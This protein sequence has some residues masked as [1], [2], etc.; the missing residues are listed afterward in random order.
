MEAARPSILVFAPANR[1]GDTT[2]RDL[3]VRAGAIMFAVLLGAV[4]FYSIPGVIGG[5]AEEG[6]GWFI[7]IG[8]LTAYYLGYK[9][10]ESTSNL[11][12]L[13]RPIVGFGLVFCLAAVLIPPFF[14]TDVYCYG[15]IGWQQA[16]YGLNPYVSPLSAT[17]NWRAD[18]LFFATC[19]EDT[20]SAY[21]FLFSELA[22]AV[23]WVANGDRMLATWIFKLLNVAVFMATGW[24]IWRG[25]K[26]LG[27]SDSERTLYLFLWNPLLLLHTV[28]DG[29]NDLLMGL[30]TAAG[31]LCAVAGGCIAA[32]PWLLGG[33]LVK[34]GSV[35]LMPF[36]L[37]YLVKR[38]G[39]ARTAIGLGLGTVLC[40]SVAAPYLLQ[41]WRQLAL[42][43]IAGNLGEW[44]NYTLA[45]FLFYPYD[46]AGQVF[47]SL[48]EYQPQVKS[49]IKLVLWV[50]FLAVY[51][52]LLLIRLRGSY[53]GAKLLHDTVLVQF[54]IVCLVSSK[55]YPWYLG[56]F[57][58]LAYLL[59]SGDKLR[60][61]VL[62]VTC[63][64]VLQFTFIRE[65]LALNAV[66]LLIGPLAYVWHVHRTKDRS[67]ERVLEV[68]DSGLRKA[69]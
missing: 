20:P 28:S 38:Y 57:V 54:L 60:H 52:R 13:R 10:L 39:I 11:A 19:W 61:A 42:G 18:P 27:R 44:R 58:P 3:L 8:T 64:Q 36:L 29:H 23:A 65:T 5:D 45:A 7:V 9:A 40:A 14:S 55:F 37:L 16:G 26:Y 59:P 6:G 32:V 31:V 51:V 33:A 56:M 48:R 50:G 21:G 15:N 47:P 43:R 46:V 34:Y 68:P 17:P 66:V 12:A 22:H 62:A 24:L 2:G 30:C 41:D 53:D 35:I 67:A 69:A 63:A 1:V 4:G 49:A 25:C